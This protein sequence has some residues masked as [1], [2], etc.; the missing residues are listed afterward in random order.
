MLM[1][2][3]CNCC[4]TVSLASKEGQRERSFKQAVLE[5]LPDAISGF[6]TALCANAKADYERYP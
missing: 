4:V 2:F 6:V 3:D 5:V 1:T